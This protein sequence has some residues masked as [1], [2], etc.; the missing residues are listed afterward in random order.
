[1]KL[2]DVPLFAIS[3]KMGRTVKYDFTPFKKQGV[4]F[5]SFP[6][7][8]FSA[9][10]TLKSSF[11]RWRRIQGVEGRFEYDILEA[12]ERQPCAIVIWKMGLR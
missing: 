6:H 5:I 10:E 9:Y 1:M 12:T 2:T 3:K 11:A 4:R 8:T 7:L